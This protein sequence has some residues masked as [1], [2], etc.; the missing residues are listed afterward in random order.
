[1]ELPQTATQPKVKRYG[2]IAAIFLWLASLAVLSSF[3]PP[4]QSLGGDAI[5]PATVKAGGVFT[6]TRS[7]RVHNDT[8]LRVTRAMVKGDCAKNCEIIDLPGGALTLAEG[9]YVNL[10]REHFIPT[11]A[12]AGMWRM[13]FT[14][15]WQDA[16]WRNRYLTLME[17][18]IEVVR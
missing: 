2:W 9:S 3:P 15:H 6:V 4:V 7:L 18:P 16:L 5:E 14:I 12:S 8:A 13:V 1:M 11:T 10:R 17:L